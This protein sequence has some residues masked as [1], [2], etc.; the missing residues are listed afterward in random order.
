MFK[1]NKN[2]LI[3]IGF[4]AIAFLA[5]PIAQLS[6]LHMMPG[7]IGD[8]RLNNYFLEN[9]YQYLTGNSPSLL[10]LNFFYPF[11]YVLG[12]SDNLFGSS[13]VYLLARFLRAQPDTAFQVW[14]LA[15]Y[16]VNFTAAYYA[17]RKLGG[18]SLAASVGALIFTF[19]LPTTAHAGHAQLHYRFGI[20]LATVFFSEFLDKKSWKFLIVSGAWLVWQFYAGV[21]MGFFTLLLMVAML[22]TYIGYEI[23]KTK[24]SLRSI[25]NGFVSSWLFQPRQ[26]KINYLLVLVLLLL[27]MILLFYP[28]LQ[29]SHLYGAKRSWGEISSMLPRP[30]SYF[31]SDASYLWSNSD[32]KVFSAIPMRHE[33]QMLIGLI[34]LLLAL[35]GFFVGSQAKNGTAFILMAGMIGVTIASTL[36]L[37]GFSLWYLLHK[38][39][40]ASAIRAMTRLDQAILFPIAYLAVIAVDYLRTRFEWGLKAVVVLVLPLLIFEF[41]MTTMGT[42]PK[43]AWRQRVNTAEMLI[44]SNLPK[45][46]IIFMAQR[47]GPFFAD[48]LDAMWVAMKRGVPTLNGYSGIFPPAFSLIYG[49]D[50]N[51]LPKRIHSY[52]NFSSENNNLEVYQKLINRVVPIGFSGCNPDWL[53]NPPSLTSSEREY[54]A[55]EFKVLSFEYIGRSKYLDNEYVDLKIKN[56]GNQAIAA[57][58]AIGKPVRLSWR[59]VDD[60]G[61]PLT[62]WNTRKDLPFDVPANGSLNVRIP[63]DSQLAING[64]QLQISIVQELVFW[65]HDIGIPPLTIDWA[66]R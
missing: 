54:S 27:L 36:Y 10:H 16:A 26:K 13:P 51:E 66:S 35:A 39:P 53:I 56:S 19:A 9:L 48:E 1:S 59:F 34:P 6:R 63:I 40:L 52:L 62:D 24:R 8:A 43:K 61:T 37:G 3:A 55:D 4:F 28:Y 44:P 65:G 41:S 2:I 17:L 38:L 42:S 49:N 21:Y 30:Q 46:V 45:D 64:K 31:L 20:P 50:C 47:N 29:V 18:S 22:S 14:F 33:H 25:T 23:I 60:A 5:L 32:S 11:S 7:D 57:V 12:F 58:S 15:G